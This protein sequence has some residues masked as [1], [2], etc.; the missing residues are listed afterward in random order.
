LDLENEEAYIFNQ[1]EIIGS[2]KESFEKL[3]NKGEILESFLKKLR[4]KIMCN[5]DYADILITIFEE[6]R[7]NKEDLV[8][9]FGKSKIES[10]LQKNLLKNSEVKDVFILNVAKLLNQ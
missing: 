4:A 1:K 7:T 5:K 9:R 10:L 8:N 6:G 2:Y 3:W